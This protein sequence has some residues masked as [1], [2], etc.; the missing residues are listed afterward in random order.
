MADSD[1]TIDAHL[2]VDDNGR[3]Y[4]YAGARPDPWCCEKLRP[5]LDQINRCIVFC[6]TQSA[7]PKY[8]FPQIEFC[9]WCGK[10]LKVQI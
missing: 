7:G 1:L 3:R 2:Q 10:K 9:P 4:D 6:S 8:N 5:G